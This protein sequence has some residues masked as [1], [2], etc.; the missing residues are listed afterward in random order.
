V[1][2]VIDGIGTA[3]VSNKTLPGDQPH[4][5]LITETNTER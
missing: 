2:N 3:T 4:D 5:S 1:D